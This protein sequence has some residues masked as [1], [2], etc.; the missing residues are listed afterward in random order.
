M[1][2]GGNGVTNGAGV[3][4][5]I[6]VGAACVLSNGQSGTLNSTGQCVA[7]GADTSGEEG[8]GGV[9]TGGNGPGSNGN[10]G[11]GDGGDGGDGFPNGGAKKP[12]ARKPYVNVWTGLNEVDP[13]PGYVAKPKNNQ[14]A[15]GLF[16]EAWRDLDR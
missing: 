5:A 14:P 15:T 12:N 3:C 13:G 4:V 1:T 11:P 16:S 2:N 7:N 10:N 9:D 6:A 8:N